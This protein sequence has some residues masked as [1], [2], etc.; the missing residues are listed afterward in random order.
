MSKKAKEQLLQGED[1]WKKAVFY[2][3][4]PRSFM[5]SNGDGIGDLPGI[6]DQLDYLNDGTPDSLGIDAIWFSPFFPSPQHDF[7][8][9][10]ADYCDID[11]RF[12]TL[13]DFD[14]LVE[15]CHKR[16]IRVMLDLVVN[17]TSD[18][19]PWFKESRS[20]RD[21]PKRDWYIWRD[22]RGPNN[23]PPNNWR[24]HFFGPAWTF[25][26]ATGQYYLHSFLKEQPDLNWYNPEV[27]KA[28]HEV[29]RFWLD[30]GV[31]GFRLDVAHAYCKDQQLRSNPPFFRRGKNPNRMAFTDQDLTYVIF[32]LLGLPDLQHKKYNLH[33]PET[34]QVLKEFRR[35]FD[36]YP[37]TT[38]IG[39]IAGDDPAVVA[40]YYGNNDELHMNFY[41]D[42]VYCRFNADSFRR[43]VERWEHFLPKE[44]W[45]AYTLSN[46]DVTRAISRFDQGH[47]GDERARLLALFLLTLRGT[48]FIYYGEEIGMKDPRLPKHMLKDPVGRKWY[49]F[50]RGR[51]GAR[52]PMQ[53]NSGPHAGFTWGEPWLP[54]GPEIE[55][56]NVATQRQDP[57]SLL[58]L[59]RKLIWTRKKLPAL[60]EGS[61]RTVNWEVPPDCYFY[62]RESREQ[63]LLVL[64]NFSDDQ[65]YCE[66]QEPGLA[67]E[68]LISTN[69]RRREGEKI[70]SIILAPYEGCLIK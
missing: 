66:L 16:G 48:P 38:S 27:R 63:K 23:K 67:G 43:C 35:I 30:R 26:E 56:R 37:G 49:P 41:F 44:A 20:S 51:D 29:I 36:A 24:N 19:H 4:Y 64:L 18:Q 25:D 2:Q 65:R 6:I 58:S 15:E 62:V 60:L 21:N 9:D 70:S 10:I 22:G 13:E 8:Y 50:Y 34:H 55:K 59:Y 61:Y 54:V 57:N 69:P 11:P 7:G 33:H 52:T 28:I 1:W 42:F 5:D 17:H 32:N 40:S 45:P 68:I 3:I 31:D 53:W 47:R 46:H 14:R 12:G 39:E